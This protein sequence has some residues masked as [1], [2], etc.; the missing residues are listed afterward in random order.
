MRS[1][2]RLRPFSGRPVKWPECE[3]RTAASTVP[4]NVSYGPVAANLRI[5]WRGT[6]ATCLNAVPL[7]PQCFHRQNS[8]AKYDPKAVANLLVL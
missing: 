5:N 7:L 8:N 4:T 3:S 6:F 2:N 1:Q